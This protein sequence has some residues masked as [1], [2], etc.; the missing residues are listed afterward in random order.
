[1]KTYWDVGH[2]RHCN[3]TV[4]FNF[5][6]SACSHSRA[7]DWLSPSAFVRVFCVNSEKEVT[8]GGSANRDTSQWGSLTLEYESF[9]ISR[10]FILA[11]IH[12]YAV[13]SN[14]ILPIRLFFSS[15]RLSNP[16][17]PSSL[18]KPFIS[19]SSTLLSSH[20][21][22]SVFPSRIS[23]RSG[24]EGSFFLP[25]CLISIIFFPVTRTI[26]LICGLNYVSN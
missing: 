10:V 17:S 5:V 3:T 25:V 8:A 16:P 14:T 26:S 21:S 12:S 1:M 22:R 20:H 18:P 9:Q 2:T 23:F 19:L 4:R 11:L 13:A 15:L 7:S 24:A 6:L